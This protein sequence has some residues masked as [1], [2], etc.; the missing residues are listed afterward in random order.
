MANE[1][2]EKVLNSVLGRS[3]AG[4]RLCDDGM[5]FTLDDG[6]VL[7]VEGDFAIAVFRPTKEVSH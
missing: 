3:L 7:I 4:W 2:N 5:H 1:I 6:S